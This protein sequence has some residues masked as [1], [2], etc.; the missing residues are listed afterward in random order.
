MCGGSRLRGEREAKAAGTVSS[1]GGVVFV[2]T[3]WIWLTRGIMLFLENTGHAQGRALGKEGIQ[4][5]EMV[6]YWSS[7][8]SPTSCQAS[9]NDIRLQGPKVTTLSHRALGLDSRHHSVYRKEVQ[10]LETTP[11]SHVPVPLGLRALTESRPW[12]A[13][14]AAS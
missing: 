11:N 9:F 5:E 2:V 7:P 14:S 1:A 3:N 12:C 8:T 4:L 10:P 13:R 6:P